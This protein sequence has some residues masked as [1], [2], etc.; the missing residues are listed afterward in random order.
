MKSVCQ[1]NK[2]T[3]CLAC[4]NICPV[5]A[6]SLEENCVGHVLPAI[7]EEKCTNCG[8]CRKVCPS[9][10]NKP[11]LNKPRNTYAAWANDK[12]EHETSTSGGVAAVLSR[13]V[14]SREGVV[15]GCIC[16]SCANVKHEKINSEIDLI[17]LKGSKYVQSNIGF[18]Y[19]SVKSH[20]ESGITVLFTGT[21]CQVAGLKG[22]LKKPYSNLYT[23]DLVCHGV[24]PQKLLREHIATLGITAEDIDKIQFR[25]NSDY[26]LY[27]GGG[28]G[29]LYKKGEL[30]DIYLAGFND[31]LFVRESCIK[32]PYAQASRVAD[33]TVGD[34]HGLGTSIPFKEKTD[35]SISLLMVNSHKGQ[36]LIND[37]RHNLTLYERTLEEAVCGNA[38]LQHATVRRANYN[39]FV[40]LYKKYGYREDTKKRLYIDE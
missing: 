15:Y 20:L 35:G 14:L 17:K 22:Y 27:I 2:C 10:D 13:Y 33:I 19:K 21:P 18:I 16:D 37:C 7:I 3:G 8:L 1:E 26:V 6:I 32:C 5:S 30:E 9:L 28:S 4:Y 39:K 12:V 24:P 11:T 34:F 36:E 31:S 23:L 29:E 40:K 38:Q 25:N